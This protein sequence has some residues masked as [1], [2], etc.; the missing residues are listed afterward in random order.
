MIREILGLANGSCMDSGI[1]FRTCWPKPQHHGQ[2][3]E[4][5]EGGEEGTREDSEG[6]ERRKKRKKESRLSI[7]GLFFLIK[8]PF[9]Q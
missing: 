3:H 2:R 7:D 5:Q 1:N 4:F 9:S 6:E 8:H